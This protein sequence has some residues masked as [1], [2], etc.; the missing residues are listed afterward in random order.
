MSLLPST[1]FLSQLLSIA[2][3]E[4]S[5]LLCCAILLMMMYNLQAVIVCCR[6]KKHSLAL[7]VFDRL[8]KSNTSATADEKVSHSSLSLSYQ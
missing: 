4:L 6:Q 1:N 5:C 7:E 2:E 8:W 3:S